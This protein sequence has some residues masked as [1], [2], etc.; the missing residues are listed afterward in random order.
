MNRETAYQFARRHH[1]GQTDKAGA[2]YV[3]HCIAVASFAAGIAAVEGCSPSLIGYA[4]TA[5][6]LHDV[7][8]DT[9]ATLEDVDH[10]FGDHIAWLVGILSKSPDCSRSQYLARCAATPVTRIVKMADAY[11]NSDVTRFKNP[12]WDQIVRCQRYYND[13]QALRDNAFARARA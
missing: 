9:A 8:E 5:G 11:H 7:V 13:Y 12:T 10:A 2:P 1:A 3:E 4:F 6:L